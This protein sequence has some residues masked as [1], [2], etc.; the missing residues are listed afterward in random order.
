MMV[1]DFLFWV[2]NFN[3]LYKVKW[4]CAV[5]KMFNLIENIFVYTIKEKLFEK[6]IALKNEM[7]PR[8]I[9]FSNF[10]C[11]FPY[12]FNCIFNHN[13]ANITFCVFEWNTCF[14]Y[15]LFDQDMHKHFFWKSQSFEKC[16]NREASLGQSPFRILPHFLG[17]M[18]FPKEFSDFAFFVF[19]NIIC[20]FV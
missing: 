5:F 7:S 12:N 8:L 2:L 15:T 6:S 17:H 9:I 14:N 19:I 11:D 16:L 13:F 1:S 10:S 4:H 18:R 20:S 3:S